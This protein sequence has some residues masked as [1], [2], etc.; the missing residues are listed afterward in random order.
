ML[1]LA[2]AGLV[3]LGALLVWSATRQRLLAAGLDPQSYLQRHLLNA[4]IGLALATAAALVDYRSLRAYAPAFYAL[5]CLGLVVV[6][7][8]LGATVNGAHSWILLPAGFQVQ[9][10]EFA[11]VAV[12][13]GLAVL[14]G[15]R[16]DGEA[17]PR[18]GDVLL[19]LGWPRCRWG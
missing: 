18:D 17:A 9:P 8:P 10:S 6:L 19:G 13:V 14:L 15:E 4:A 11:K 5:S 7:T 1:A 12:V 3:V 16:R 2:V